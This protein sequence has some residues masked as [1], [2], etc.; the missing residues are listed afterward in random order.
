MDKIQAKAIANIKLQ[1][2]LKRSAN[3][4][5]SLLL[6]SESEKRT[7][8]GTDYH[9]RVHSWYEDRLHGIRKICVLIDDGGFWAS[10]MPLSVSASLND[11][12]FAH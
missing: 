2:V 6:Q 5:Q 12:E 9:L 1:E 10:A 7:E 11:A 8:Q 3:D 4:L